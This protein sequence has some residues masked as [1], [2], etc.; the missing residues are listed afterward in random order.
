MASTLVK[1]CGTKTIVS[2]KSTSKVAP[3]LVKP[4]EI[5]AI[6][7]GSNSNDL[8][9]YQVRP[10]VKELTAEV[11][12][13]NDMVQTLVKLHEKE[14]AAPVKPCRKKYLMEQHES[15]NGVSVHPYEKQVA[16]VVY[17]EAR[18]VVS[19]QCERETERLIEENQENATTTKATLRSFEK[20]QIIPKIK[21]VDHNGN[22]D[23]ELDSVFKRFFKKRGTSNTNDDQRTKRSSENEKNQQN[24]QIPSTIVRHSETRMS[25]KSQVT[26]ENP[27]VGKLASSFSDKNKHSRSQP[28]NQNNS[29]QKSENENQNKNPNLVTDRPKQYP[30][31]VRVNQI[32]N[33]KPVTENNN[34]NSEGGIGKSKHDSHGHNKL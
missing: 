17:N 2:E 16:N 10:C 27:T 29:K 31:P 15:N 20:P 8:E 14:A 13:N 5:E 21:I 11:Q 24:K 25:C 33:S 30:K 32:Q 7:V 22:E 12:A 28:E 9:S 18:T 26:G 19:M 6:P 4:R 34:K 1:P 23:N 3:I